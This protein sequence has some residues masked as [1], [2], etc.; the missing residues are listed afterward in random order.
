MN[1]DQPRGDDG[2]WLIVEFAELER[3]RLYL[4]RGR[5]LENIPLAE[6]QE[7]FVEETRRWAADPTGPY[8]SQLNDIQ[9][10]Y[11]LRDLRAPFSLV[12][13]D[14]ES[15][16]QALVA[17]AQPSIANSLQ[18]L[19]LTIHIPQVTSDASAPT[20]SACKR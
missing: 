16:F 3:R 10:E 14:L 18:P 17:Q 20:G 13:S 6:L 15:I 11:G 1:D 2:T 4:M 9:C 8:R 12:V 7:L 19:A 5:P